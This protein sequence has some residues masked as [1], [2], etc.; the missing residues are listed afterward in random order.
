MA[1]VLRILRFFAH[2]LPAASLR[3]TGRQDFSIHEVTA[4]G[5]MAARSFEG[6]SA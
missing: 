1:G 5:V 4:P 6:E 3:M 2:A